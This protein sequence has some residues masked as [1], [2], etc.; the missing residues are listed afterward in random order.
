MTTKELSEKINQ[1]LSATRCY[2]FRLEK[3]GKIQRV[4]PQRHKVKTLWKVVGK[5]YNL[6]PV[7]DS[8]HSI[9][10]LLKNQGPLNSN[11]LSK[12]LNMGKG[13]INKNLRKL[14]IEGK[15]KIIYRNREGC[16]WDV[17]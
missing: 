9:I 6:V 3:N 17:A 8:L 12:K 5:E 2:L 15:L 7:I 4:Y 14:Q 16:W 1:V 13:T 10:L 11:K